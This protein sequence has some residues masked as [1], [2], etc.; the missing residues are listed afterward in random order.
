MFENLRVRIADAW[1]SL[2]ANK[3]VGNTQEVQAPD[4]LKPEA[5]GLE[6]NHIIVGF[7]EEGVNIIGEESGRFSSV[8]F[9]TPEDLMH[10]LQQYVGELKE[11]GLSE[12]DKLTVKAIHKAYM[13][14]FSRVM[15]L[16]EMQTH[17]PEADWVLKI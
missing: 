11:M 6:R 5:Y 15:D 7:S 10:I 14:K 1:R 16:M 8:H 4:L 2:G 9:R 12:N 13:N 3:A 17:N